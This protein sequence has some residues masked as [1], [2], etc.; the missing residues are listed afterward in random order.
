MTGNGF[1][2]QHENDPKHIANAVKS[3]LERK[4]AL[5]VMDWPEY[6]RGSMGSPGQR[7]K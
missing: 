2:F 1:I 7:K 3:Y 4:T 5:T 6:Y